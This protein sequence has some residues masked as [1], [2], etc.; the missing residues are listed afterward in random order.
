MAIENHSDFVNVLL[1]LPTYE[2]EGAR[3]GL[4]QVIE[5]RLHK[6]E[7]EKMRELIGKYEEVVCYTDGC[8]LNNPGL[9]GVGVV[10]A[11]RNY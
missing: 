5:L 2:L 3:R 4:K 9:S 10:F 8:S 7:I 11:G 6:K 1:K